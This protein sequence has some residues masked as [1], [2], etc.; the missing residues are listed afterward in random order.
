MAIP[1]NT[2]YTGTDIIEGIKMSMQGI[3]DYYSVPAKVGGRV[4]YTGDPG[5]TSEGTIVRS[6]GSYLVVL[7]DGD[8]NTRIYHP[9]WSMEYLKR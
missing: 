7:M 6:R 9:T 1:N 4:K 3:R 8:P 5:E 2:S